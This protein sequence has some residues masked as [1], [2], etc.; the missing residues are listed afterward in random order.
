M[1]KEYAYV[2]SKVIVSDENGKLTQRDYKENI[3]KIFSTIAVEHN[4]QKIILIGKNGQMI[5]KI[6]TDARLELEKICDKKVFLDLNVKVI[7]NW[8]KNNKNLENML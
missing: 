4:S 8:R 3:D 7:K 6:G 5:K 1:N 2:D